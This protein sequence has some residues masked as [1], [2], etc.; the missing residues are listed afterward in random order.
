MC[1]WS[2][3]VSNNFWL[4]GIIFT[5]VFFPH[6]FSS[7]TTEDKHSL[8]GKSLLQNREVLYLFPIKDM[9]EHDKTRNYSY[10]KQEILNKYS[11]FF[12]KHQCSAYDEIIHYQFRLHGTKAKMSNLY[13]I[14][15][16]KRQFRSANFNLLPYSTDKTN[17]KF[18]HNF[19]NN[20]KNQRRNKN[21]EHTLL[22][23]S[24]SRTGMEVWCI[25][26]KVY[27]NS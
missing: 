3:W 20:F 13:S 6:W 16:S 12:F 19:E 14:A 24:K 18:K 17:H 5:T 25:S 11:F 9:L 1:E 21:E 2:M 10:E 27:Q 23:E 15:R 8:L 26:L 22:V 7:W 4:L